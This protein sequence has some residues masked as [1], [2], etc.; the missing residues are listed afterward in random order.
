M[1]W[2]QRKETLETRRGAYVKLEEGDNVFRLFEFKHAVN[3]ADFQLERYDRGSVALGSEQTEGFVVTR[4]HF[5]PQ[6]AMCNKVRSMT[7]GGTIGDCEHCD[8]GNEIMDD[9]HASEQD[10]MT[11]K[12]WLANDQYVFVAVNVNESPKVYRALEIS[13]A[14]GLAILELQQFAEKKGRT[15]FGVGGKDICIRYD[16]KAKDKKNTYRVIE[17]DSTECAKLSASDLKGP[18]TDLFADPNY[19]GPAW[20]GILKAHNRDG[21]A[22]ADAPTTEAP[23]AQEPKATKPKASPKPKKTEAPWPPV[24]DQKVTVIFDEND[25][26]EGLVTGTEEDTGA[27]LWA[28]TIGDETYECTLEEME[29]IA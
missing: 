14:Q 27:G 16:K 29:K 11:A 7:G 2:M 24:K 25:K 28:V 21:A 9:D 5:K 10:K 26:Q 17:I 3:E 8:K 4:K 20:Q 23:K 18:P 22:K 19:V 1:S 15:I 12:R 13:R 6:F